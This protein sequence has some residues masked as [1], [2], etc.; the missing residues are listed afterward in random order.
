VSGLGFKDFSVGEVLTSSDVDGYLMQQSVM[1]FASSAARGSALGTA[2]GTGVALSEGMVTYLDDSNVLSVY[3]GTTWRDVGY[4]LRETVY[5]TSS[6][7]FTKATYPWLRAVRVKAQASGGGG[8]RATKTDLVSEQGANGAGGGGYAESFI[9][10]IAGLGTAITVTVGAGG[11]TPAAT[12]VGGVIAPTNGSDSSFGTAVVG[13][14]SV[15]ATGGV[16]GTGDFTVPGED[17]DS[18]KSGG[19]YLFGGGGGG[20]MLGQ[21]G[22]L[23]NGGAAKNYGGGGAGGAASNSNVPGPGGAGAGGIVIVELFS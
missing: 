22:G 1:R 19:A 6:G 20:S 3:D 10:D 7:T 11:A 21:G 13:K 12:G 14:G 9:T 4:T 15:G 16:A 8:G 23:G 18:G 17:G 2:A 5:F